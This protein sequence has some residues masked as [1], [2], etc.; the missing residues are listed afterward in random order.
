MKP[1]AK[2]HLDRAGVFLIKGCIDVA[3][4]AH[5]PLKAEYAARNAYYAACHA[6]K[7][8]IFERTGETHKSH[9]GV[10]KLFAQLARTEPAIDQALRTF[11]IKAYDFKRIAD[12]DVGLTSSITPMRAA[13]AVAEAER[14]AAAIA[15]VLSS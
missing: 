4:S 7:A 1:E 12:Y 11:L 6:A 13:N 10:H 3:A 5:E 9:G 8:L 15:T 2:A 14:F